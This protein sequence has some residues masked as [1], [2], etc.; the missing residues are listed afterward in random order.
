MNIDSLTTEQKDL[1]GLKSVTDGGLLF[2]GVTEEAFAI[3][4][5]T[6]QWPRGSKLTW[7]LDVTRL[8]TLSNMDMRDAI[9]VA[10]KEISGCCD[11]THSMA[12]VGQT[13]NLLIISRLMDGASGV[14]ADC[15]IPVGNVNAGTSLLMRFDDS[16]NWVIQDQP[17]QGVIDFYRV[18]LHE[19]E[20]GHGL[21]HK[22]VSI[23]EPALI[24]P[25]YSRTIR[26]LQR[27]D[28]QELLRRYGAPAAVPT[29]PTP[30]PGAK[31]VNVTVEQDGKVWKGS[32]PRV[33]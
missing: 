14:L 8:G 27:V 1:L 30:T 12:T 13:P 24:A 17:T 18:F 23:P 2:C 4:G 15:Q 25:M 26:N 21:G 20:H 33:G 29:P 28:V 3:N 6:H 22:P 31:P 10:L 19:A 16:E 32:I 7:R 9:A 5:V 11:I